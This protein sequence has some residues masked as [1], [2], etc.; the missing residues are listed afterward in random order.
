MPQVE[1]LNHVLSISVTARQPVRQ[2]IGGVKVRQDWFL[3]TGE[4]VLLLQSLFLVVS[5]P[6]Q[7]L[8]PVSCHFYSRSNQSF[9]REY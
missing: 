1:L 7:L 9:S 3:K 2:V 4:F 8:R 6:H 5:L